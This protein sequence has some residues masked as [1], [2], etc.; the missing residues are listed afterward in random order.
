MK[1]VVPWLLTLT[2]CTPNV[3]SGVETVN[4]LT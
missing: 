2:V 4:A 3:L 1:R